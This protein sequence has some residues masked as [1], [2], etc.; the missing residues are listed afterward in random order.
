V[1]GRRWDPSQAIVLC[2]PGRPFVT[3]LSSTAPRRTRIKVA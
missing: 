2:F 3:I 1:E